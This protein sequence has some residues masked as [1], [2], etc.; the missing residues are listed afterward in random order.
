M[1]NTKHNLPA[2]RG[3]KL[4]IQL[5][6]NTLPNTDMRSL[7]RIVTGIRSHYTR[8]SQLCMLSFC[9]EHFGI[10]LALLFRI[11]WCINAT[12]IGI[13]NEIKAPL[14]KYYR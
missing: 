8:T 11:K 2:N 6:K 4:E 10:R 5:G 14:K 9:A 3:L 1:G 13:H 12:E 7:M